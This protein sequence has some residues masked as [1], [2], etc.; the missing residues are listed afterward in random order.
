M[1]QLYVKAMGRKRID[2]IQAFKAAFTN[3][4]TQ[5]RVLR[6]MHS[7]TFFGQ[8]ISRI[9]Q[10]RPT[11]VSSSTPFL[12]RRNHKELANKAEYAAGVQG[13]FAFRFGANI[14]IRLVREQLYF[15]S[16]FPVAAALINDK[17]LHVDDTF[18]RAE[19]TKLEDRTAVGTIPQVADYWERL[20]DGNSPKL[21]AIVKEIRAMIEASVR[22]LPASRLPRRP[23][24]S[25]STH[26]HGAR[27]SGESGSLRIGQAATAT[28]KPTRYAKMVIITP[29]VATAVY[30]WMY[31]SQVGFNI[32]H[33]P[34]ASP[35]LIH[36]DLSLADRDRILRR[37]NSETANYPHTLL[38][39]TF[40]T[41]GTAANLQRANYEILTS[42]L[43][44]PRE[45][46]QAF[47]RTNRTGQKLMCVHKIL[48]LEDNPV[49]RANMAMIADLDV[50][51][52][53]CNMSERLQ[54][55]PLSDARWELNTSED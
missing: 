10:I 1:E 53:V 40:D 35:I 44:R 55:E 22:P 16:V 37:F 30:L 19:I 14:A 15:A 27:N 28:K 25:V 21:Q 23:G 54:T 48:T 52:N 12:Y 32:P 11:V 29:T 51:S 18:M 46:T 8:P 24:S 39:G 9:P 13:P 47:G 34:A 20:G 45:V 6:F 41:I 43:P 4:F 33:G 31:L 50:T 17:S 2:D 5:N 7:S 26:A 42:P 49:D 3:L 38:I 36:Q